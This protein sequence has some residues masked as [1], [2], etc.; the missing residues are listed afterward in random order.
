MKY[1][2]NARVANIMVFS[3]EG[4][5]NAYKT[6]ARICYKDMTMESSCVLSSAMLDMLALGFTP[7]ECEALELSA[8]A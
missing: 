7:S 2:K 4:A 5:E 6:L 8:I 3:R 1:G